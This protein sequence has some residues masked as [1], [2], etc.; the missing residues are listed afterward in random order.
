MKIKITKQEEGCGVYGLLQ[1]I[2]PATP[3]S[4]HRDLVQR[5]HVIAFPTGDFNR[6]WREEKTVTM[7][8]RVKPIYHS[9]I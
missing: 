5:K 8:E 1:C 6:G 3:P 2:V 4:P 7:N 9:H